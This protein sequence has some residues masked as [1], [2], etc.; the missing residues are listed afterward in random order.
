[1]H[2]R[3]ATYVVP[4]YKLVYVSTPK[5]ACAS[6]KWLLAD[7]QGRQ[8]QQVHLVA[9]RRDQPWHDDPPA[10][11]CLGAGQWMPRIPESTDDV[12]Y[13]RSQF[14][15]MLA[16]VTAHLRKQGWT[17]TLE[18]VKSNESPLAVSK[19]VL[20]ATGISAE[21][22]ERIGDLSRRARR[23][24]AELEVFRREKK[25]Q[26]ESGNNWASAVWSSWAL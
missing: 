19:H 3:N 5:A 22:G 8:R 15:Q 17:G 6:I 11:L 9:E 18:P 4:A 13:D 14:N 21:R 1:V 12:I 7:L 25:A 10:S 26:E 2:R 23:M 16:E 24:E 20:S